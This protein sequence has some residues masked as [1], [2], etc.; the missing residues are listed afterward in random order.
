MQ[1]EQKVVV[2]TLFMLSGASREFQLTSSLDRTY[3]QR[4][5]KLHGL[6]EK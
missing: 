5:L 4:I 2:F 6:M 1:Y 3:G